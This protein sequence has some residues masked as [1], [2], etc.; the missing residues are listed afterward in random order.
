M[1]DDDVLMYATK[2]VVGYPLRI[3]DLTRIHTGQDCIS[4]SDKIGEIVKTSAFPQSPNLSYIPGQIH[5]GSL[6]S[7]PMGH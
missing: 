7:S 2:P 1:H 4:V 6:I 3:Q 5:R